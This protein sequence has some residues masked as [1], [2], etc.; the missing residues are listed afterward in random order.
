[1]MKC[2]SKF[3]TTSSTAISSEA[4]VNGVLIYCTRMNSDRDKEV[5]KEIEMRWTLYIVEH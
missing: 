5:L 1:M 2:R 4:S 3:E